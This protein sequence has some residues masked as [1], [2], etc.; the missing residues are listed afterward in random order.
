MS[1]IKPLSTITI[2]KSVDVEIEA[3]EAERGD[4]AWVATIPAS[5][6]IEAREVA[7]AVIYER[8][9]RGY[10]VSGRFVDNYAVERKVRKVAD[11]IGPVSFD[12]EQGQFFAYAKNVVIAETLA[13]IVVTK[14]VEVALER[15]EL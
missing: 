1:A 15:G 9:G 4:T 12:S 11:E 13:R 3:V 5:D 7:K 8:E 10:T 14:A 6:Y 2:T